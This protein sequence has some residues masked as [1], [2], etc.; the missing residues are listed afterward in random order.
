MKDAQLSGLD[1]MASRQKK[2]CDPEVSNMVTNLV[3]DSG[4]RNRD[5]RGSVDFHEEKAIGFWEL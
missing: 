5:C 3:T 4:E 2:M 1:K